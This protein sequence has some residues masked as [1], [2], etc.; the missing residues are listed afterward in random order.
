M[1]RLMV[2]LVPILKPYRQLKVQGTKVQERK[3]GVIL[4]IVVLVLDIILKHV[5]TTCT[6]YE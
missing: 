3:S 5:V 2:H 1:N 4:Q 6:V